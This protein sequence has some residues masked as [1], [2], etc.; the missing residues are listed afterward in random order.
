MENLKQN[1]EMN[2]MFRILKDLN[3]TKTQK[4][5]IEGLLK[6]SYECGFAAALAE[7]EQGEN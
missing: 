7:K 3:I 6:G 5:I 2:T 1:Q 4:D